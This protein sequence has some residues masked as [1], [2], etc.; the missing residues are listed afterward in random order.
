MTVVNML[1]WEEQLWVL[2]RIEYFYGPCLAMQGNQEIYLTTL[3]FMFRYRNPCGVLC[4]KP[5]SH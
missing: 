2:L 4:E 5:W 1:N 3:G